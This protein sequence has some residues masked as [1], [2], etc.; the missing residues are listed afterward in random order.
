MKRKISLLLAVMV[1]ITSIFSA[2]SKNNVKTEHPVV[3]D[4]QDTIDESGTVYYADNYAITSSVG[5]RITGCNFDV[6]N[7]VEQGQTLYSIENT[8]VS[9]KITSAQISLNTA[10][11]SYNQAVK[12]VDDLSVKSYSSG[13]IT[14]VYCNT[15]DY[16]STGSKIAQVVDSE[17]M[18]LKLPFPNAENIQPGSIAKVSVSGDSSEIDGT[19]TKIY[20][21]STVLD[22][23]HTGV[24]IELSF[25]NPGALASGQEADATI[26]GT[27][28]LSKGTIKYMT[29]N[30]IY[31][32]GTG[33]VTA[34][35]AT[36]GSTVSPGSVV[37]LIK[38][39]AI[40]N[41]VMNTKLTVSNTEET[42]K[43]LEGELDKYTI[44]A[45]VSG[46]ILKRNAK[47]G[48]LATAATALA[49]LSS[50]DTINVNVDIDEKYISKVS[51]GQSAAVTQTFDAKGTVYSGVVKEINNSGT[52]TNG[53]TYYTV[54]ISLDRQ[55]GLKD[56]MNVN[57][58]ILVNSKK[59]SLLVPK[60][61]LINGN[62]I[63]VLEKGKTVKKDVKVGISDSKKAEIVSGLSETDEVVSK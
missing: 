13:M 16:V 33:M 46:T 55:D 54:K 28:S 25:S 23:W 40:T 12:S 21:K 24:F 29:D 22:D 34:I 31:S 11:E 48:D 8:D 7:K 6:G 26:N 4:I 57:V 14:E 44:K 20:D 38:N 35:N 36:A 39:D 61:Y 9:N 10:K 32:T 2:C 18:K 3:G 50:G 15:G 37:L 43:Q 60:A 19:V 42:L 59:N 5:G 45:P 56:G 58:S 63:E 51:V 1:A 30:A 27:K 62:Q 49:T 47:T 41:A 17:H 52:V 53:V